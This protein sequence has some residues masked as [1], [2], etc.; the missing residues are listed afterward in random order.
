MS[1]WDVVTSSLVDVMEPRRHAHRNRAT[2]SW[3]IIMEPRY[4]E[5]SWGSHCTMSYPDGATVS[6][7][8]VMEPWYHELSWWSH[9]INESTWW[10]LF[11]DASL[12]WSH[13]IMSHWG[14]VASCHQDSE[15]KPRHLKVTEM[16]PCM[17]LVTG[18]KH[19]YLDSTGWSPFIWSRRNGVMSPWVTGMQQCDL[20]SPRWSFYI[21]SH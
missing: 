9:A 14:G 5:L 19:F 3:V 15:I 12:G 6:W 16:E 20:E 17:F 7:V 13:I 2:V 18:V 10:S 21:F 11:Q 4:H 8:I 1:H